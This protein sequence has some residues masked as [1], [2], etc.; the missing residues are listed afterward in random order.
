MQY[1]TNPRT[2]DRLSILGF[3]CMRLPEKKGRIDEELATRLIRRAIDDGVNYVDTAFSY[4]RGRSEPFLAR[5]LS[6][7]YRRRVHLATK[8]PHW[9]AKSSADFDRLLDAQLARLTTDHIDYYLIHA[10]QA[11]SWDR[12]QELGVLEFLERAKRDGKALRAGFSFHGD[13]DTFRS[14]VDAYDWDC[15]LIQ[16]NYLDEENQAGTRGL[17]HAAGRGVGVMVMEPLR[18]GYLARKPPPAIQRIGDEAPVPRTPAEWALRWVW[19]RPEVVV[20]ISGMN[21]EKHLEENLRIAEAAVPG[22]LTGQ[23]LQLVR[24]MSEAHR[25]LLKVDC[26]GCRYCMPCP[27]GVDIATCFEAFNNLHT[28]TS[29]RHAA[30][31][32]LI[33]LAGMA[34]RPPSHAS[35]C[36]NCG[37]C[38]DAC[39]QHLPIERLLKDVAEEFE[40]LRFRFMTWI[41]SGYVHLQ[42][43]AALRMAGRARK[44]GSRDRLS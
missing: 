43:R 31:F 3:G 33:R 8:L 26:T 4:H 16:Y 17:E 9:L 29:R 44:P 20:A 23:E 34:G 2:G 25:K 21:D 30:M 5:A 41:A 15:C 13:R 14:I 36:S 24:R 27:A 40:G 38:E 39:P 28:V 19:N 11:S 18:G 12:V 42:R 10:L 32:Y 1:R 37:A 22:S 35:L 7:G 6:D